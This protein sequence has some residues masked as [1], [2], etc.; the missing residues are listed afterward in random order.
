[1]TLSRKVGFFTGL[2]YRGGGPM[3]VWILHRISGLGMIIFVSAHVLLS[4]LFLQ[5]GSDAADLLNTVYK[6]IYFQ[7]FIYFCVLFHS[8]NGLRIIIQDFWPKSLEYQRELIWLEWLV[9]IPIFGLTTFLMIQNAI[10]S[11]AAAAAGG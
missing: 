7:V 1:M 10:T 9:F 4:F 3:L 2:R 8:I 11:A 6:S 5:V